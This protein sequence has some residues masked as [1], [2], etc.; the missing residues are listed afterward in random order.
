[1]Y[2]AGTHFLFLFFY[3]LLFR[4]VFEFRDIKRN[5]CEV[6]WKCEFF[7]CTTAGRL[8]VECSL[9][10]VKFLCQVLGSDEH[11]LHP[12][13]HGGPHR[14][15]DSGGVVRVVHGVRGA[16]AGLERPRLGRA[17]PPEARVRRVPG[18][19]L[20]GV[21]DVVVL[22]PA[23]AG[24]PGAVL[25]DLPGGAQEDPAQSGGRAGERVG[26]RRWPARPECQEPGRGQ[27]GRRGGRRQRGPGGGGDRHDRPAPADHLRGDHHHHHDGL[28]KRVVGEHVAGEGAV[29][30]RCGAGPAD[31]RPLL[32]RALLARP[33]RGAQAQGQGVDG[34]EKRA[35]GGQDF[36]DYHGRL[37]HV[38]AALLH[39]GDTPA[40]VRKVLLQQ[41]HGVVFPVARLLQLHSKPHHLHYLQSRVPARLQAAPVRAQELAKTP[42]TPSRC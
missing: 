22:L 7:R 28:H 26:Q 11:R 31:G 17:H 3:Y 35:E 27:R 15:D 24:D 30:E 42:P 18:H 19:V 10:R 20:P 32:V 25:A 37:R 41:V 29:L 4:P 12:S 9:T 2:V 33:A 5:D 36:S 8:A 39:H 16:A 6:K 34:L 14:V 21:C 40:S 1:M 13:A 23:P 38:L